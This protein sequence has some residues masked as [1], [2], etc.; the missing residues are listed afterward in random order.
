MV[1]NMNKFTG[2]IVES[3]ENGILSPNNDVDN[4]DNNNFG[5]TNERRI[6]NFMGTIMSKFQ[7]G[8]IYEEHII[9][10][11]VRVGRGFI[12]HNNHYDRVQPWIK[13][14]DKWYIP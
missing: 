14:D 11:T 3:Y 12:R 2:T 13:H 5:I 8:E 10:T 4:I 6:S 7:N 9:W 1:N